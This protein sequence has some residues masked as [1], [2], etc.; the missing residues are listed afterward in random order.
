MTKAGSAIALALI[1]FSAAE[2]EERS[3][4]DIAGRLADQNARILVASNGLKW[5]ADGYAKNDD[6][7]AWR[8]KAQ[9][10]SLCEDDKDTYVALLLT[11]R[12]VVHYCA[13]RGSGGGFD[14]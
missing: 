9:W 10:R 2:A 11:R 7:L 12:K 13:L 5:C 8:T 4:D 14:R 6:A 1:A 3:C